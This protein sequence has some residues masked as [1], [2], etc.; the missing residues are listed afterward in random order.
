M[1]K[2]L[3]T[4]TYTQKVR[5]RDSLSRVAAWFQHVDREH[6]M[7]GTPWYPRRGQRAEGKGYMLEDSLETST[8][9]SLPRLRHGCSHLQRSQE[10]TVL[11]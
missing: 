5:S 4:Y 2:Q 11:G 1:T 3:S 6:K 8:Y 7:T 10:N 9:I